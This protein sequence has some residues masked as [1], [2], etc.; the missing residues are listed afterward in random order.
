MRDENKTREQLV[1]ELSQLRRQL[2]KLQPAGNGGLQENYRKFHPAFPIKSENGSILGSAVRDTNKRKK[3]ECKLTKHRYRLEKRVKERAEELNRSNH[4]LKNQEAARRKLIEEAYPDYREIANRRVREI[5][6][7]G[8]AVPLVEEK[9]I[10]PDGEA[11]DVEGAA[12]PLNYEGRPSVQVVVRDITE[13]KQS[14]EAL[15]KS[16]RFLANIFESIHDRLSIIDT[17]FNIIRANKKVEESYPDSLP[18]AGKKCYRVYHGSDNICEGCPSV[19]TLKTGETTNR[20]LHIREPGGTISGWLDHYSYPLVDTE[21]GNMDGVVVYA[22]DI[23]EKIKV[24]QEMARLERLNLVGEMAASIGHEV[25]NPMTTVRGFLQML[26]GREEGVRYRDYYNLMIEELDRA[27]SIITQFLTLARNKPV[28]L[29]A[30]NLNTVIRTLSPLI[31]ASAINSRIEVETELGD[32]PD[33]LFNE[34]EIR[35]LLLN[36]VRNGL[37]AMEPGGVLEIKTFTEGDEV[38]L[39]VKDQGK[40]I[41]PELLHRIGT[42][43]FTT[44]DM[45]TGLG[46]AVCYS[47]ATRHSASINLETSPAGTTFNVRFKL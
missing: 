9:L 45:G 21:T 15:R 46:L 39:S 27:N 11:V 1:S 42:P 25:R 33:M 24:E 18:L 32:I 31:T 35:Q 36:L 7:T 37:E 40:G 19:I 8:S 22:R 47:I 2:G 14:E 5:L 26:R 6:K 16:E 4:Q 23:T 3:M 43:F 10:R 12:A 20:V 34:K 44:K 13:R 41:M 28:D 29:K 38:V 17:E 30:Q